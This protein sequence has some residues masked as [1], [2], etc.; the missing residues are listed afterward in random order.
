MPRGDT[1]EASDHSA[2]ILL[3]SRLTSYSSY[4]NHHM[5]TN[6]M[7]KAV[8]LLQFLSK[9]IRLTD[10]QL[11]LLFNRLT[12]AIPNA[13][14]ISMRGYLTLCKTSVSHATYYISP[15]TH[16]S[17]PLCSALQALPLITHHSTYPTDTS[18]TSATPKCARTFHTIYIHINVH[19]ASFDL[20][21]RVTVL[22]SWPLRV[23]LCIHRLV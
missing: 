11:T 15:K 7:T 23:M 5:I 10:T 16:L 3:S 4:S 6:T 12:V 21:P 19:I 17:T 13:S 9:A 20:Q 22:A 8:S 2:C 1:C 14:L 18:A